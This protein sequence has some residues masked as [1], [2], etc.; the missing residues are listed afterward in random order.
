M[1]R[2]LRRGVY[3]MNRSVHALLLAALTLCPLHAACQDEPTTEEVIH[4]ARNFAA[5]QLRQ[6]GRPHQMQEPDTRRE[7]V[8]EEG[9]YEGDTTIYMQHLLPGYNQDKNWEM[10]ETLQTVGGSAHEE[11]GDL[12]AGEER[13]ACY[14]E[15]QQTPANLPELSEDYQQQMES[16]E[17]PEAQAWQTARDFNEQ[18]RY[19]FY[20]A[21]EGLHDPV[22]SQMNESLDPES[23][24]YESII[25]D[26]E[27]VTYT[28]AEV[29]PVE[30]E[31]L[32]TC[33]QVYAPDSDL[34]ECQAQRSWQAQ[35]AEDDRLIAVLTPLVSEE[36]CLEESTAAIASCEVS[37]C[38]EVGNLEAQACEISQCVG[39]EGDELAA[40]QQTCQ[41][42][43]DN[44]QQACQNRGDGC[45][46]LNEATTQFCLAEQE[47]GGDPICISECVAEGNEVGQQCD[48][49][50]ATAGEDAYDACM[51]NLGDGGVFSGTRI[52]EL[53]TFGPPVSTTTPDG[54]FQIESQPFPGT[55]PESDPDRFAANHRVE[56]DGGVG[57]VISAGNLSNEF[58][59]RVQVSGEQVTEIRFFAS[60]VSIQQNSIS[61][62]ADFLDTMADGFC[63]GEMVCTDDPGA[64][65]QLA[66]GVTACEG[67]PSGGLL[68]ALHPWHSTAVEW[69]QTSELAPRRCWAAQSENTDC[70]QFVTGGGEEF[71]YED[72]DGQERCIVGEGFS[73]GGLALRIGPEPYLDNCASLIEREECELD[74]RDTCAQNG[75]GEVTGRCYVPDVVFDCGETHWI[76]E[77]VATQQEISCEGEIMCMGNECVSVEEEQ[78][79]KDRA[80]EAS[81][82]L[83]QMG[84]DT[85]CLQSDDETTNREVGEECTPVFFRGEP[86][87]CKIP[88]GANLDITPDC[89][90][91][92]RDAASDESYIEYMDVTSG[93]YAAATAPGEAS[94]QSETETKD[95]DR[96]SHVDTPD[97]LE[98]T[99]GTYYAPPEE[100][101]GPDSKG[102]GPQQTTADQGGEAT[103][104][105]WYMDPDALPSATEDESNYV[106][107]RM[108]TPFEI[109]AARFG[110]VPQNPDQLQA[111]KEAAQDSGDGS[112]QSSMG[113]AVSG[114]LNPDIAEELFEADGTPKY[115]VPRGSTVQQAA[116]KFKAA[117]MNAAGGHAELTS[118]SFASFSDGISPAEAV[119]LGSSYYF[120]KM[121]GHLIFKCTEEEAELGM[122]RE[123]RRCTYVGKYCKQSVGFGPFKTCI[124]SREVH[125]C[126][127]SAFA[128]EFME[129]YN[130]L[131]D[132]DLGTPEEPVCEGLT[133][134]EIQDANLQAMDLT[135]WSTMMTIAGQVPG[136]G[137]ADSDGGGTDSISGK[138]LVATTA[139]SDRP[140]WIPEGRY[141]INSEDDPFS[142]ERL[143]PRPAI[144]GSS[145]Y[146][147]G[148][149]GRQS[150]TNRVALRLAQ[151]APAMH[152]TKEA[153]KKRGTGQHDPELM[154]WYEGT[155]YNPD[156]PHNPDVS[157]PPDM[158]E[159]PDE[160]DAYPPE[161]G[162]LQYFTDIFANS[163]YQWF[164][165]PLNESDGRWSDLEQGTYAAII[166]VE[167]SAGDYF[168]SFPGRAQD[169]EPVVRAFEMNLHRCPGY[170][171]EEITTGCQA[172]R[173][174]THLDAHAVLRFGWGTDQCA[175]GLHGEPVYL[176]IRSQTIGSCA[177]AE[178]WRCT[179]EI[180][181]GNQ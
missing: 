7:D 101:G 102:P 2:L 21:E 106:T 35:V 48:D 139:S 75:E 152:A 138:R 99:E 56:V 97:W 37:Q 105:T 157:L 169:G 122:A 77:E 156:A 90:E 68:T 52:F 32:Q 109:N 142:E 82:A 126:Y 180:H 87:E 8:P 117:S 149:D 70:E 20:S 108:T 104:R 151:N 147:Y 1:G 146:V 5:D 73:G 42:Q 160:C 159:V 3:L 83:Q 59:G 53:R 22:F 88:V 96:G 136:S 148:P 163:L 144:P 137:E 63:A 61:G 140:D 19:Q 12:P 113:S 15:N 10:N 164:P 17:N 129:S 100:G 16:G 40:C 13:D 49:D 127:N 58:R 69:G 55:L 177:Q 24:M 72:V 91:E 115:Q 176:N 46:V 39:L 85:T 178:S 153:L 118:S 18:P 170:F 132:L 14:E 111:S 86:M 133:I 135:E 93:V 51:E 28:D 47:C 9:L 161:P 84:M 36:Q 123:Q 66:P 103:A 131:H 33:N 79:N 94:E 81:A 114:S 119:K 30:F 174:G 143:S 168:H 167:P 155:T 26:C 162:S 43:G 92:G 181:Y 34:F 154:K 41:S 107:R 150:A 45:N 171:G 29:S 25:G 80:V 50:C 179:Q 121:I 6:K 54:L 141:R 38:E 89:C 128:R 173:E 76:E 175:A 11:C 64:C 71:C 27:S 172:S 65:V 166:V 57:S 95:G 125:C 112:F 130:E 74:S 134:S 98:I 158:G 23:P 31:D 145:V 124:E 60:R 116:Q 120:L 67:D 62:C 4:E 44:A 110:H 78:S 165:P